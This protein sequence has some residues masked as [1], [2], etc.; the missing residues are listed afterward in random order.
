MILLYLPMK[1]LLLAQRVCRQWKLLIEGNTRL[2]QSLFFRPVTSGFVEFLHQQDPHTRCSGWGNLIYVGRWVIRGASQRYVRVCRNPLCEVY[3]RQL[4]AAV[5]GRIDTK[6]EGEAF[7][8]REASWRRM[9]W[10]QPPLRYIHQ[11]RDCSVDGAPDN[12]S[13]VQSEIASATGLT[14]VDLFS[15]GFA[16][17]WGDRLAGAEAME[18]WSCAMDIDR[19]H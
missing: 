1:D 2:Q 19:V 3:N 7:I 13:M 14:I 17:F 15:S 18:E 12:S 10:A 16:K 6:K 8:R 4:R 5:L 9:L 11:Y